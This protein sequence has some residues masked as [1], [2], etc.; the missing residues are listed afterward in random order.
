MPRERARSAPIWCCTAAATGSVS[1]ASGYTVSTKL[2]GAV[3]RNRIRRRLREIVRLNA[4]DLRPGWDIVL[5]ARSRCVDAPWDKLN[6][7][8]RQCCGKLGLLE[9]EKA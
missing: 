3:I 5:V 9:E 8:Y 4:P 6:A 1:T 2:G 7:A